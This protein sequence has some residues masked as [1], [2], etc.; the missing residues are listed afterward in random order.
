MLTCVTTPKHALSPPKPPRQ[1]HVLGRKH[2]AA[3]GPSLRD[4]SRVSN[5]YW[6]PLSETEDSAPQPQACPD[7]RTQIISFRRANPS[8]RPPGKLP[9][10]RTSMVPPFDS[11]A[12][13]LPSSLT[14][15]VMGPST[16][17]KAQGRRGGLCLMYV[18]NLFLA[19]L[20]LGVGLVV[21]TLESLYLRS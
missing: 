3:L 15:H 6:K 21:K 19:E 9:N 7:L 5:G 2:P 1:P 10:L 13:S 16:L 4:L 8:Q 20:S 18:A 12:R 11:R 17:Q 14:Q